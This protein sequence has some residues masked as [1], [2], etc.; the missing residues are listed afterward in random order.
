[1]NMNKHTLLTHLLFYVLI[2]Y[3]VIMY[4]FIQINTMQCTMS[5]TTAIF[6]DMKTQKMQLA[7]QLL[8]FQTKFCQPSSSSSTTTTTATSSSDYVANTSSRKPSLV[9][10]VLTKANDS[11]V[12]SIANSASNTDW[13]YQI[14]DCA[15]EEALDVISHLHKVMF[16]LK[17]TCQ[18][19]ATKEK[20]RII[21]NKIEKRAKVLQNNVYFVREGALG[22]RNRN[23]HIKTYQFFLFSDQLIYASLA[24]TGAYFRRFCFL[25]L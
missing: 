24:K 9:R 18:E 11:T 12:D 4:Q 5:Q 2:S 20:T 17:D 19:N 1:M 22:K 6:L 16:Y 15:P 8:K 23:G 7:D 13:Y 3:I 14:R 21:A 10:N 25:F